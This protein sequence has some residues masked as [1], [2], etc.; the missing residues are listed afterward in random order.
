MKERKEHIY[1]KL[2]AKL[3]L[4]FM[5]PRP[6]VSL[7]RVVALNYENFDEGNFNKNVSCENFS[8]MKLNL[9]NFGLKKLGN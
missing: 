4:F 2:N 6:I 3:G 5:L 9:K 8:C 1:T 7:C